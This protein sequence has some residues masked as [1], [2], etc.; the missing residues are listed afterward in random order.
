MRSKRQYRA[1][2]SRTGGVI[3]GLSA[4]VIVLIALA[5]LPC[6]CVGWRQPGET[7]AE[8]RRKHERVMD[9]DRQEMM[10]DVERTLQLDRPSRLT[11]RRVP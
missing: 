3:I 1:F 7:S 11:D 5:F 4:Y 8:V 6:G 9:I 2:G 10:E